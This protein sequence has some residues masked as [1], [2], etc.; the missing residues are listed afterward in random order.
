MSLIVKGFE[1]K[2]SRKEYKCPVCKEVIVYGIEYMR[3]YTRGDRSAVCMH[4]KCHER[5]L[6]F[7]VFGK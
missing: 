7:E 6:M 1:Q 5:Q 4:I 2:T 3:H